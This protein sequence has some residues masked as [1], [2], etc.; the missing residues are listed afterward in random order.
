MHFGFL[1]CVCG[2]DVVTNDPWRFIVISLVGAEYF[3]VMLL[4]LSFLFALKILEFHVSDKKENHNYDSAPLHVYPLRWYALVISFIKLPLPFHLFV[5]FLY[6]WW[7]DVI[8]M[9]KYQVFTYNT[10]KN[11]TIFR[12]LIKSLF[13]RCNPKWNIPMQ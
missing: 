1:F 4:Q 2:I 5:Q 8:W 11:I 9:M 12:V 6:I 7:G 3:T 13:L 10:Q